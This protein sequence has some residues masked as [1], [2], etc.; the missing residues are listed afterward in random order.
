VDGVG[1]AG[2]TDPV[3]TPS[4]RCGDAGVRVGYRPRIMRIDD[5]GVHVPLDLRE[6]LSLEVGGRRVWAFVPH[7]DGRRADGHRLV[8]WPDALR[9]FLNGR[10]DMV[11]RTLRTGEVLLE[12]SARLGSGDG[13]IELVDALGRP[14][15][16]DKGNHVGA[17][18]FADTG[19]DERALVVDVVGEALELLRNR[20]TEAFLA[21]GNLL[22]AVRDGRLIGHDNDADIAFLARSAHPVD[23][24]LESMAIEREF[25][26]AG[27]E[28]Y[29]M[30][31]ADFKLFATLPDGFRV[32]IDVFT[33]FYL[34]GLLHLMPYVVAPI[35]PDELLPLSAVTLEGQKLAAPADPEALLEA[36]YGPD[37]RVP[38]PAFKYQPSRAVRRR[39]GGL[40]RGERRHAK[41]WQLFYS[42]KAAKVP[43]EPSSFARWVADREPRPTSLV[44]VG[45]GTGRDSLW[46][47]GQ[48]IDVLGCDYSSAGVS[49][50]AE[51]AREQ[52]VGA[53]FRRLNL[54]D[55]RQTLAVG[56][57]LAR[58][59]D[60]DA[61]YARF[62]VHALEN[63]GRHNLWR[64]SRSALSGTRGRLYLEFRTEATEHEFGEH[65][66]QFVQPD[67]VV[68]ELAGHGFGIEHCEDRYGLAVHRNEDPRVCRI[69]A[70]L[71]D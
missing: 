39:F 6:P 45:S 4:A 71:E 59:R 60:T 36:T 48:D 41:Y 11:L 57:L 1:G 34:D 13:A 31:G 18:M 62:L 7:R 12:T 19:E 66:R 65:F 40:M 26:A 52:Q 68:A 42:T 33:A 43:S 61:V 54:Y 58:E 51:R 27:W 20:G 15:T 50:A 44:D 21:Y 56:A 49:F 10:A 22:G 14:V 29:R 69:V 35:S 3:V 24:I 28:T 67:V 16:V 17:T 55:L 38:D 25:V 32:G 64:F 63:D 70:K 23:V 53:A 5:D 47:A 8:A 9:P 46:L 2:A 37:W 30:S